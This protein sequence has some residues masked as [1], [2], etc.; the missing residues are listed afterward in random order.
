MPKRVDHDERRRD[1]AAA[2]WRLAYRDGWDAV[3]LRKVAHEA[4][5]S[6][7]RVQYYFATT[8]DMLS[9][10]LTFVAE[11]LRRRL[12]QQLADLP[13]SATPRTIVRT[14]LLEMIPGHTEPRS[15]DAD[16]LAHMLPVTGDWRVVTLAWLAL[17]ARAVQRPELAAGMASG[18]HKLVEFIA[19][20]VREARPSATHPEHDAG[21]LLA[22]VDGLIG[23]IFSG[24]QTPSSAVEIM[25]TQLDHIF[26]G[27]DS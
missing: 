23:H 22:L 1:I 8:D 2:L 5:V 13:D 21:A 4:G 27:E 12:D 10:A 24:R 11:D 18:G 20:Q 16:E 14:A 6:M 7:G 25:E 15:P 17:T 3:S 19:A 9:F 26:G